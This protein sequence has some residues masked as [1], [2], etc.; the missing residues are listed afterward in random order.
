M[1]ILNIIKEHKITFSTL[2]STSS[3]I[4]LSSML[5]F[6]FFVAKLEDKIHKQ[7]TR[8]NST[9]IALARE[10]D[11]LVRERFCIIST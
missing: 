9:I 6:I 11:V 3:A 1:Y 4:L 8:G 7:T 2:L 5:V 10:K